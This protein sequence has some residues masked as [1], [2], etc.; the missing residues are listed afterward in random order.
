MIDEELRE[1]K[2]KLKDFEERLSVLEKLFEERGDEIK[3]Q[4]MI[5]IGEFMMKAKPQTDIQR[6]LVV[7]YFLENMVGKSP[8]NKKDIEET[9]KK[10]K[11]PVPKNINLC[12]YKNIQ[13]GFLME[14][15]KKQG[16]LKTWSLTRTG[17]EFVDNK[18]KKE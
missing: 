3:E 15:K 11:V 16:K 12:V 17:E 6:T 4:K 5:S 8:F 10:A 2:Q 13:H 1:I 7:A 14:H 18:I 9:F